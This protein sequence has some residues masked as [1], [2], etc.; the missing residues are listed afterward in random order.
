MQELGNATGD[1]MRFPQ[2]STVVAEEIDRRV[3]EEEMEQ[4]GRRMRNSP[5]EPLPRG[6]D[7]SYAR[8]SSPYSAAATASSSSRRK[9]KPS[10]ASASRPK[11]SRRSAAG[12][13]SGRGRGREAAE[14]PDVPVERPDTSS[15][16]DEPLPEEEAIAMRR[17][18]S[19]A[20]Y[21][22]QRAQNAAAHAANGNG[23]GMAAGTAGPG[24]IAEPSGADAHEENENDDSTED[25]VEASIASDVIEYR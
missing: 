16:L 1:S 3:A 10:G 8:G 6:L 7:A 21:Q 2:L 14:E 9:S 11:K 25:M 15:R 17:R 24:D 5:S 13:G 4:Y 23:A 18:A 20:N 12:S 22:Q 19:Y